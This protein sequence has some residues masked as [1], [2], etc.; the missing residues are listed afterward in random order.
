MDGLFCG[1]EAEIWSFPMEIVTMSSY[2][3]YLTGVEG[4]NILN[5]GKRNL[6]LL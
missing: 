2:L 1:G 3:I 4:K 6:N 5:G